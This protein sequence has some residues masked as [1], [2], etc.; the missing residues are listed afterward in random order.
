MDFK[1][2]GRTRV[3]RFVVNGEGS[4]KDPVAN[5]KKARPDQTPEDST[6][7]SGITGYDS[8]AVGK[9]SGHFRLHHGGRGGPKVPGPGVSRLLSSLLGAS[10][11]SNG[12][13][14]VPG[15]CGREKRRPL[16]NPEPQSP[17]GGS[18][19]TWSAHRDGPAS[20]RVGVTP[21]I[22]QAT[23]ARWW[24]IGLSERSAA[25]LVVPRHWTRQKRWWRQLAGFSSAGTASVH[26][27][28][29]FNDKSRG[30]GKTPRKKILRDKGDRWKP[31]QLSGHCFS[32]GKGAPAC[33]SNERRPR[34][35]S[36]LNGRR[37]AA[38]ESPPRVG[39]GPARCP[40]SSHQPF[41]V[42]N[43]PASREP[44]RSASWQ[45]PSLRRDNDRFSNAL[46]VAPIPGTRSLD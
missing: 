3:L 4:F 13:G 8:Q 34:P 18:G 31:H 15:S 11:S 19:S 24:V 10:L 20:N 21:S 41:R 35:S 14:I 43:P 38:E 17:R 46:T 7:K 16:S 2:I 26:R 27:T 39:M 33:A 28:A 42:R 1:Q 44:I 22:R 12:H 40:V 23:A 45:G 25:P 29:G 37:R 32:G 6:S 36:M 9:E 30:S 5:W